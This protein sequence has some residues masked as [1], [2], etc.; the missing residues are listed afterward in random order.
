MAH[1]RVI[2]AGISGLSTA[3]A[4]REAG[5]AV[6]VV[7]AERGLAT[8]SAAAGA[9]WMPYL[10]NPPE[11]VNRWS[12]ETYRWLATLAR[13]HPEAGVDIVLM[14]ET[15]PA[16]S[17]PWWRAAV[18]PEVPVELVDASPLRSD[19]RAWRFPAP[20]VDPRYCMPWLE[21]HLE[22]LGVG[23]EVGRVG[24]LAEIG[25]CDA[26]VN[27]T[28]LGARRLCDDAQLYA[29]FGQVVDV[30]AG[31][32]DAAS[33]AGDET[34]GVAYIIPRRDDVLVLG[35]CSVEH[36]PDLAPHPD[37]EMRAEILGR[38]ARW[39]VTHGEVIGD[40]CGLRPCRAS[41][42]VE[43]DPVDPRVIH[44]YGHGGA[45]WTMCR[46]C[47]TEIVRLLEP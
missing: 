17:P 12:L 20:R 46:G 36:D 30:R 6:T 13:T 11:K 4:L 22:S 10:C 35:G 26:V 31:G 40:R 39:G 14:H 7:A 45:G 32:W 34:D 15:T 18:P 25:D 44:N 1:V 3:L 21:S 38:I 37:D 33:G 27:C 9:I 23:I 41:V 28:G 16:D 5:H 29:T 19:A 47:A 8:T 24:S 43:R 2:G 42:R